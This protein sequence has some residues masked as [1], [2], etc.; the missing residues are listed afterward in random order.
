MSDP[1][2]PLGLQHGFPVLHNLPE[3]AQHWLMSIESVM[4]SNHLILCCPLLLLFSI[5]P[6][7]R[8]FSNEL[9]FGIRWPKYWS[10]SVYPSNEYSGLISF[11]ID[12]FGLLAVQGTRWVWTAV[13]ILCCRPCLSARNSIT[14]RLLGQYESWQFL[15]SGCPVS[16]PFFQKYIIYRLAW[17]SCGCD[18]VLPMQGEWVPSLVNEL[19]SH[20]SCIVAKIN[21]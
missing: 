2:R 17:W 5:F 4:P 13:S 10:F 20:K 9:A 14:R 18:S 7:I 12:W 3:F 19:R 8:V 16:N 21:K 6:S 1:L 15:V 11:R